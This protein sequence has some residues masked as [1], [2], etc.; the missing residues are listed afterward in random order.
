MEIKLT[1]ALFN[2]RLNISV[3][4]TFDFTCRFYLLSFCT[5]KELHLKTWTYLSHNAENM[6]CCSCSG[7]RSNDSNSSSEVVVFLLDVP[8]CVLEAE[9]LDVVGDVGDAS[10]EFLRSRGQRGVVIPVGRGKL[11][12]IHIYFYKNN[13]DCEHSFSSKQKKAWLKA[14]LANLLTKYLGFE[15]WSTYIRWVTTFCWMH[16]VSKTPVWCLETT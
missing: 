2:P 13:V 9:R 1:F 5:Y 4:F 12:M 7:A 3:Q 10:V 6:N 8:V 14:C 11:Q 16:R 15:A